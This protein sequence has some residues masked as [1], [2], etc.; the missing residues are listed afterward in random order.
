MMM[1]V[2]QTSDK[3]SV[4]DLTLMYTECTHVLNEELFTDKVDKNQ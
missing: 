3:F 1:I 4:V 2:R